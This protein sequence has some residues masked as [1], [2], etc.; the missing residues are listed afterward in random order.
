M[1]AMIGEWVFV[2]VYFIP[3]NMMRR[4]QRLKSRSNDYLIVSRTYSQRWCD[5]S[6]STSGMPNVYFVRTNLL[7]I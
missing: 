4:M 5:S 3:F 1:I 7:Q 6:A 2:I